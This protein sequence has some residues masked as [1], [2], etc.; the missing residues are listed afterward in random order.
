MTVQV[1][2]LTSSAATNE[3][4]IVEL[5][6]LIL[7]DGRAISQFAEAVLVIARPNGDQGTVADFVKC[8]DLERY[9]K[10]LV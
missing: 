9:R 8:N 2:G 3:S 10:R 7:H 4:K 5:G 6:D 1:L